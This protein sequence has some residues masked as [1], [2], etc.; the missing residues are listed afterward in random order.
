MLFYKSLDLH[1]NAFSL[2]LI[3]TFACKKAVVR[4]YICLKMLPENVLYHYDCTT[5]YIIGINK[6]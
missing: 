4:L 5:Y 1:F 3:R 6:V 2:L